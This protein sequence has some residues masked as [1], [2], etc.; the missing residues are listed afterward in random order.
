MKGLVAEANL[1]ARPHIY[2]ADGRWIWELRLS[3]HLL[4]RM[5]MGLARQWCTAANR[6]G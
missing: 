4:P 1:L 5:A 3:P 6:E 2:R